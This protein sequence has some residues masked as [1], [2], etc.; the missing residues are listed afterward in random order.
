MDL[1]TSFGILMRNHSCAPLRRRL[2][3]PQVASRVSSSPASSFNM[4]SKAFKARATTLGMTV[5]PPTSK[6]S[7]AARVSSGE[8]QIVKITKPVAQTKR[9]AIRAPHPHLGRQSRAPCASCRCMTTC[10]GF[11]EPLRRVFGI[12]T[13]K[14]T[15]STN[16]RRRNRLCIGRRRARLCGNV[17]GCQS[18]IVDAEDAWAPEERYTTSML[19]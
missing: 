7:A 11:C 6:R 12:G 16:W 4:V 17:F 2:W 13:W 8:F 9:H 15:H 10:F 18:S 1:I 19:Q 14:T 3:P 5:S